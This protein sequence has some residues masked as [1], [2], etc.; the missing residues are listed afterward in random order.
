MNRQEKAKDYFM[1]GY[2]CSQSV[3]AAFA[4]IYG[5]EEETALKLSCSF[6]AGMGR[7]REVCGAVSGMFL[8]AGLECG[9]TDPKDQVHKKENYE[10]VRM[11]ADKFKEK[12]QTI[13]CR[14]LLGIRKAE[15]EAAPSE[16]TEEYYKTRPCVKMVMDAAGILEEYLIKQG[17]IVETQTGEA[18]K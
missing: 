10:T 8:A 14:E 6:G 16:R 3:F 13:I 15:K 17:S 11:L 1:K 18:E 5:I 2:N 12:N 4:D 7:M 9:N